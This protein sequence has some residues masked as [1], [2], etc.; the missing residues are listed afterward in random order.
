MNNKQA[1]MTEHTVVHRLPTLRPHDQTSRGS[2]RLYVRAAPP[3]NNP[4][5]KCGHSQHGTDAATVG[6]CQVLDAPPT[7]MVPR[8]QGQRG[9]YA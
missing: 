4:T 3:P 8:E 9:G 1:H 5:V 6:G 2:R 7:I